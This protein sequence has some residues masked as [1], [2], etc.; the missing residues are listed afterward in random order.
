MNDTNTSNKA[1]KIGRIKI[2]VDMHKASYRVVRQC[3][4]TAPEPPQKFTPEQFGPWLQKQL[5]Q[6][7]EVFVCY[8]AGCF[9]YEPARRWQALG[10]KVL[11]IA[12]QNWDQQQKRQV[13]DKLDARVMC[14][15]L[16]QHL[17]GHRHALSIVRIPT[18]EEEKRRDVSRQRDQLRR[19]Q[20]SLQAMGRSYLLRHEVTIKGVWWKGGEWARLEREQPAH[21]L[22]HLARYRILLLAYEKEA[23]ELEAQ[24]TAGTK[25]E[26]LFYGEGALSHELLE[27]EL[28]RAD[29]FQNARQVGNYFGLCPSESTTSESRHLGGITKH[30]NPRLRR[31][32]VELAWRTIVRQ[33]NYRGSR[34]WNR[35]LRNPKASAAARKKAIV[36]LARQLAVDLWR[37]RTGR[38]TLAD[39]GLVRDASELKQPSPASA[40]PRPAKANSA[41]SKAATPTKATAQNRA[42][43]N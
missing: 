7:S 12:P 38:A 22:A 24:L 30:G 14:Q 16:S 6:A 25:K 40:Q 39:L 28:A 15:R 18:R 27:R 10:A 11:V 33:P 41:V 4:Y 42:S 20:R 9:G 23:R 43:L 26:E 29:R 5:G 37:V 13:N 3:D 17:D 34:K 19:Q 2:A 21:L 35:V 1:S 36:A 32:M 8:E 31:L